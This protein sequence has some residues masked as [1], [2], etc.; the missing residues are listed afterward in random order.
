M[1][2]CGF[3]ITEPFIYT[4]I[5]LHVYRSHLPG[6][7]NKIDSPVTIIKIYFCFGWPEYFVNLN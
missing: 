5:Q 2:S 4:E 6:E 3:W 7:K 1:Y